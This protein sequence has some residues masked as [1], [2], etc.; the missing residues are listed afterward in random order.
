MSMGMTLPIV[1][2]FNTGEALK[3][4]NTKELIAQPEIDGL[5]VGGAS[6]KLESF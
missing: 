4:E 5:L 3:P 2:I 6:I 1:C